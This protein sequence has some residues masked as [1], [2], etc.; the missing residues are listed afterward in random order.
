MGRGTAHIFLDT[1]GYVH[2]GYAQVLDTFFLDTFGHVGCV[3]W[4]RLA[5]FGYDFWIRAR[6]ILDTTSNGFGYEFECFGYD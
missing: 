5:N 2:F 6:W 1:L 4:I 3:F